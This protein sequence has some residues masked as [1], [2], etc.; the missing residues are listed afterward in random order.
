MEDKRLSKKKRYGIW[1][2]VLIFTC[3]ILFLIKETFIGKKQGQEEIEPI[4]LTLVY[5]YQNTQWNQGIETIVEVFEEKYDNITI[6][7]QVQYEDKVYEDI[8]YKLQARGELGDIVQLKTPLRYAKEG[9]LTPIDESIGELIEG[10]CI[11]NGSI[12]GVEAIG[13]TEGIIYNR[14]IFEQYNLNEPDNYNEFLE[15][16]EKLKEAEII[17]IG[18]AGGDLWHFGIWVNHF[19]RTDILSNNEDWN[20][21]RSQGAVSWQDEEAV[22]MLT[23]LEKLYTSGYVNED[24]SVM[25]DGNLTYVMSQGEVAM[26]YGGS[27]TVREIQKVNSEMNLGWFYVPDEEGNVVVPQKN[28]VFWSL[29]SACGEDEDK[30]Q[31]ALCFLEFFYSDEVYGELC[32]E[33]YGYPVTVDKPDYTE[34]GIQLEIKNDFLSDNLHVSSYIGD[35]ETPQGFEKAML[36]ETQRMLKGETTVRQTAKK[37]EE[38]WDCYQNQ[39][40]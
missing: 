36:L 12:Y 10:Y 11:Y 34:T 37:L 6:N 25:Q 2:S 35:E 40:K 29:T 5:A 18:V 7:T 32:Q 8:L 24:W 39:E 3:L 33:I 38:R 22:Q 15:L 1:F 30:Y 23:H 31:A 26:M 27:W 21:N 16:C 17:P 4:T 20:L 14:D 28:D 13:S 19:F 9:L